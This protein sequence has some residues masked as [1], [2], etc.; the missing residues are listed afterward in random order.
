MP[1]WKMTPP[2]TTEMAVASWRTKP[3]VAVAVAM[4][5]G[6]TRVWRAI[7]GDWKLGPTPKPAMIWKGK[8]RPQVRELGRSM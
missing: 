6:W 4:S 7:K 1:F 8:M 5:R 2:M 3:K